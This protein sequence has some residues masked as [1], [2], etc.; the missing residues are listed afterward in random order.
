MINTLKQEKSHFYCQSLAT[1]FIKSIPAVFV[2]FP[3]ALPKQSQRNR[4]AVYANPHWRLLQHRALTRE[5][6]RA[7]QSDRSADS[8]R[9]ISWRSTGAQRNFSMTGAGWGMGVRVLSKAATF[10]PLVRGFFHSPQRTAPAVLSYVSL[11]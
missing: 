4:A 6:R 5:G 1:A 10:S 11:A 3:P 2:F 7:P 8:A 9:R